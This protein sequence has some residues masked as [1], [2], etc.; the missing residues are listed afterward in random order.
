MTTHYTLVQ[1]DP[2]HRAAGQTYW[3][4]TDGD[5]EDARLLG[6]YDDDGD[7]VSLGNCTWTALRDDLAPPFV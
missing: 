3:Q 5:G 2:P 7:V 4:A 6:L 1:I